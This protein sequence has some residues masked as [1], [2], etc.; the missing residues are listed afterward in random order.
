MGDGGA[1]QAEAEQRSRDREA[2]ASG[3]G[4]CSHGWVP[5]CPPS[6]VEAPQGQEEV[7]GTDGARL[8]QTMRAG[9]P[10]TGAR[11]GAAGCPELG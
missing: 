2:T 8:G 6:V 11:G 10:V 9:R 4:L 3:C 5:A 1:G 7:L